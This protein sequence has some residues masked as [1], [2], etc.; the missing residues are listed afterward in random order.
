MSKKK[1]AWLAAILN[2]LIPGLGYLYL[3]VRTLFASLLLIS[4]VIGV[5]T[6]FINPV[7]IQLSPLMWLSLV[8]YEIGFAIDAY[9]EAKKSK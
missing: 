3:R 9:N 2:L 4:D 7:D 1:N 5:L 6:V 8:L